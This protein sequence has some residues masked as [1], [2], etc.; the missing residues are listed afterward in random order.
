MS[1]KIIDLSERTEGCRAK[2][3]DDGE[4]SQIPVCLG[5]VS[6][7]GCSS[8]ESCK[9]LYHERIG[10]TPSAHIVLDEVGVVTGVVTVPRGPIL[11]RSNQAIS[12][13]E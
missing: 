2:L 11:P 7:V 5:G 3:F 6:I 9:Q 13:Q 1:N 12:G 8:A 4:R 10:K